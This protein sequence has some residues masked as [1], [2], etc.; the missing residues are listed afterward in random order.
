[1]C[2]TT[3]QL[4]ILNFLTKLAANFPGPWKPVW[5]KNAQKYVFS[6]P[7]GRNIW[8]ASLQ[9]WHSECGVFRVRSWKSKRVPSSGVFLQKQLGHPEN[10]WISCPSTGFAPTWAQNLLFSVVAVFLGNTIYKA[11]EGCDMLWSASPEIPP[12]KMG[13]SSP[14]L[15]PCLLIY[16]D[17]QSTRKKIWK[18]QFWRCEIIIAI[19]PISMSKLRVK[20]SQPSD[21]LFFRGFFLFLVTASAQGPCKFSSHS[22]TA[23]RC[24]VTFWKLPIEMPIYGGFHLDIFDYWR[25]W[26]V[27]IESMTCWK[28]GSILWSVRDGGVSTD[29]RPK[30]H[31]NW[32]K[33]ANPGG[34]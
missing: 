32:E 18:R 13:V 14:N 9:M 11:P 16:M 2:E 22:S 15:D 5:C 33:D 27:Q 29:S 30:K 3:N 26:V 12:T 28:P 19:L 21:L 4:V 23:V 10:L 20:V 34:I 24:I 8:L 1:M 31:I 6:W 25:V 17:P 7:V